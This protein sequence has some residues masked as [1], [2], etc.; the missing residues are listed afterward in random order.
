GS[1][2]RVGQSEG[3]VSEGLR[4]PEGIG[5]CLRFTAT[6]TPQ[7]GPHPLRDAFAA[8]GWRPS[9]GVARWLDSLPRETTTE[10][11][12]KRIPPGWVGALGDLGAALRI[13]RPA[14]WELLRALPPWAAHG[15][16][17]ER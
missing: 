17:P 15:T 4:R 7:T 13:I 2:A 14:P 1:N 8:L 16:K 11:A 5:P 6:A 3:G 9:N 10:E 12:I